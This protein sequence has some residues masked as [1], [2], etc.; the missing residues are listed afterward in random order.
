M[1][2]HGS[3]TDYLDPGFSDGNVFSEV[4]SHSFLRRGLLDMS[5]RMKNLVNVKD[6][7]SVAAR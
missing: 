3:K 2:N 1:E 6:I 4:F 5:Y 7:T